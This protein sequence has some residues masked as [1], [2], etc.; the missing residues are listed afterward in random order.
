M[1]YNSTFGKYL[2]K[3]RFSYVT[4]SPVTT[5]SYRDIQRIGFIFKDKSQHV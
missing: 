1:K 2:F 5:I 4:V 3:N